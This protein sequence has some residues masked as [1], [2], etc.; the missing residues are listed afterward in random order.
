M[1]RITI[2][3]LL[4]MFVAAC[5]TPYYPG[6]D[7]PVHTQN[8][9]T[10]R[11][12][13]AYI[14]KRLEEE[15]YWLDEVAERSAQF[16][17]EYKKWNEYLPASL[18]MLKTNMDDGSIKSNGQ[19]TF[20]SYITEVSSATRAEATGFGILLHYTIILGNKEQNYYYFVIDHVY[21]DSP[22]DKA[23]IKRGDVIT[24]INGGYITSSNY[25]ALFGTIQGGTTQNIKLALLRQTT[26]ESFNVELSRAHYDASPVAHHEVIEVSGKRIGYL[27]YTSFESEYDEELL[28]AL[29]E[30][31]DGGAEEVI[32]DLRI[33]RG[34]SVSSAAM[35]CSALMPETLEGGTLCTLERN[36]NNKRTNQASTFALE[37]T[38][39]IFGLDNLTV[40]CSNYS[41]SASELVVMGLRGLDVS[42]MLIGSQTEGKNCGMDV[43]R[44][45]IG[46]KSLEFAPITFMCFNAKGEGDWG[47]GIIPD[48]NLTDDNNRYG[49]G[50]A[51]YP[52]PRADW[53]DL[54]HDIALAVAVADITGQEIST[55][56][57]GAVAES[58]VTMAIDNPALGIRLYADETE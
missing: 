7:T 54:D 26:K 35:L 8:S 56:R 34:G 5:T 44:K 40:I 20:Y 50:D 9:Q 32:L 10:D 22:A 28:A 45:T 31:A 41:A 11:D 42:V 29:Q 51:N 33:N 58:Y 17:R 55:T 16:D 23:G 12:I 6:I 38:G 24:M 30:L 43:T 48:I 4:T 2:P 47:E 3:I 18:S 19:R 14:D 53:G 1:K 39:T 21:P 27:V 13:I 25:S 52:M 15:Y 37:D 46:N 57:H 36:P 49:L